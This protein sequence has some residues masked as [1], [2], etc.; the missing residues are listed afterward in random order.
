MNVFKFAVVLL[1]CFG[2]TIVEADWRAD[3]RGVDGSYFDTK[4][5]STMPLP[6]LSV[7]VGVGIPYGLIGANINYPVSESFDLTIGA[8]L[9]FSAGI[10]YWL[11]NATDGLRLTFVYG[12][13]TVIDDPITDKLE[14][15]DD[16][17]FGV[18]YGSRSGGWDFD[19][20]YMIA[21]DD[22]KTRIEEL[23]TQGYRLSSGDA[24][25]QFKISFGYHW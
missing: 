10:R 1:G 25:D 2:A 17:N 24:E 9:G 23:E 11:S 6:G 14:T 4:D 20:I 15:Y 21:S 3:I 19:L 5:E 16:F 13:N 7:G 22:A 12:S 18:G 8:G